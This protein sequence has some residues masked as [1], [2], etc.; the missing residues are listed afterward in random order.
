MSD[1]DKVWPEITLEDLRGYDGGPYEIKD[2][3][4]A[5]YIEKMSAA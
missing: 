3:D 5:A 2:E 1:T 4:S